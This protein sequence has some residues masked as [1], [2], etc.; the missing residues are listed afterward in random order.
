MAATRKVH[1]IYNSLGAVI[2]EFTNKKELPKLKAKMR[3]LMERF[4]LLDP[5]TCLVLFH[6]DDDFCPLT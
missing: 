4:P 6:G 3:E 2:H 1:Q 5:D